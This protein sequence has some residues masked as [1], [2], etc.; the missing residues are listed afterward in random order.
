MV[1]PYVSFVVTS[2]NDNHGGDL[3]KRMRLF[4][5]GLL[6]Q[7]KKYKLHSELVFVE[8]NPPT[9]KPLLKDAL[10]KPSADDFLQIRYIV[11]PQ[12][13]HKQYKRS[14]VLG[15]FQMIAKNVGI[16][17]SLAEYVL[18]TN[19][20]LLFSDSLME[21]LAKKTLVKG[22]FY[23]AHRCDVPDTIEET[24][25][26]EKQI[27]F[28]EN[29]I[30]ARH[31]LNPELKYLTGFPNWVYKFPFLP[32]LNSLV[33]PIRKLLIDPTYFTMSTL[34]YMACGD[35]TLMHKEH[36]VEIEGYPELDL[37]SIHIDSMAINACA[38]LGLK[39]QIFP[40]QACTYHIYHREGW[41]A[42]NPKEL[43]R[44]CEKRPGLD[45]SIMY[46]A[47]KMIIEQKTTYGLNPENWGFADSTFDEYVFTPY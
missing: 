8:W 22:V 39:Q 41:S 14:D 18:C 45:W 36:W 27:R 26:F 40:P 11:V 13:V 1:K 37:Y 32:L 15:L 44:F 10:P 42:M 9:D 31:G 17:R 43:V 19:I 29:N 25:P 7:T 46:Q 4:V 2:R 12:E 28:C 16:R 20:D 3:T 38:A 34:D 21:F 30:M 33:K 5:N 23:R 35:F 24:W 47:G 6:H